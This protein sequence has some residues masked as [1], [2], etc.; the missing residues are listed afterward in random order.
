MSDPGRSTAE[1]R[2]ARQATT[3]SVAVCTHNRVSFL[4]GAIE[5]VLAQDYPRDRF[6]L[7]VIDNASTDGTH[8]LV[9]RYAESAPIP[10]SYEL[11]PRLGTALARNRAAESARNE[12]VAYLDDDTIADPGW[13]AAFDAAIREHGA[14]V[15]GGPVEPV[16]EPGV[17]A[18]VWWGEGEVQAIFGLDHSER[19]AEEPAVPIRWPLWLG[20]GNSVY[21]KRLLVDHGGFRADFGPQGKTYR[22]AEDIDLNIRLERAGVTIWYARDARIKH[23]ITGDRMTRRHLWRR[24]YSAGLT[25]AAAWALLGRAPSMAGVPRLARAALRMLISPEPARTVAGCRVAYFYGRLRQ[26]ISISYRRSRSC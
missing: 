25:D 5:S 15:A 7:I 10:V 19:L 16:L 14:R 20:A 13:L 22:V 24:A 1:R 26:S 11:E 23:R 21:A 18:P 2:D 4:A 12:Y 17:D 6:E 3:F 9:E 8:P